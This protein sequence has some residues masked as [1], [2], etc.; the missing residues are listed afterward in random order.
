MTLEFIFLSKKELLI[1]Q[2][3]ESRT[4]GKNRG[5]HIVQAYTYLSP[6]EPILKVP[7]AFWRKKRRQGY[8]YFASSHTKHGRRSPKIDRK[9]I[10]SL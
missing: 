9:R 5:V 4:N 10:T 1:L 3:V 2:I 7:K 6:S 8:A